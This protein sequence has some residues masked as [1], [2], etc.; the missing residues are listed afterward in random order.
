MPDSRSVAKQR[1]GAGCGFAAPALAITCI[2]IAVASY[3]QFSWTHN[4][5][6]DLG[7]VAGITGTIFNFGLCAGGFLAFNFAVFGLFTFLNEKW[8]GKIGALTFAAATLALMA[9]GVFNENFRPTH[10]LVS[11]AFF[12]ILPISLWI[13]TA[14]L[15]LKK[16][17]SL[18]LFTLVVSLVAAVPWILYFAV[19]YVEGVAIPEFVSGL[20]GAVWAVVVSYKMF[21]AAE[22]PK[23]TS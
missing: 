19:H 10:Y 23:D 3:S 13:I 18:A 7:V 14:A 21:K 6:S 16:E 11:V 12:T 15:W 9:I 4:A 5:L 20:S 1:S 2:L 22:K 8:V 17:K